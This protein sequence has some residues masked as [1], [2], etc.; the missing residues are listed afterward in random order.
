MR[1]G[2]D[3]LNRGYFSHWRHSFSTKIAKSVLAPMDGRTHVPK[4]ENRVLLVLDPSG[5]A[6][7]PGVPSL[8]SPMDY[9]HIFGRHSAI[10]NDN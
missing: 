5:G 1:R 8:L 4:W 6:G 3:S 2:R 10:F 9:I 7:G